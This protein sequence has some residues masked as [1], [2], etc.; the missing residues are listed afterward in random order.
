MF[1]LE[2]GKIIRNFPDKV[3]ED[4]DRGDSGMHGVHGDAIQYRLSA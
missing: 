2:E 3:P 1:S 4:G